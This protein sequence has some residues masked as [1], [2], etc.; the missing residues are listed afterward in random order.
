MMELIVANIIRP[1]CQ[2]LDTLAVAQADQAGNVRRTYLPLRRVGHF[3]EERR[4]LRLQILSQ[5]IAR[6]RRAPSRSAFMLR[7][8]TTIPRGLFILSK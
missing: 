5:A 6:H 2:R 8:S 7:A 1:R 4:Q 3:S